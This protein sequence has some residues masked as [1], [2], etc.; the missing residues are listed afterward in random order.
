MY[1]GPGPDLMATAARFHECPRGLDVARL[2]AM[3][4]LKG[5]SEE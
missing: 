1:E 3:K 4:Q 2:A 5:A